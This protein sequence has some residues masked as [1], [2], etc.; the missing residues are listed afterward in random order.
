MTLSS[1]LSIGTLRTTLVVS[2]EQP[3]PDDLGN[4]IRS[5]LIAGLRERLARRLERSADSS[6]A[7]WVIRSIRADALVN[8]AW[9]ADEIAYTVATGLAHSLSKEMS[10]SGDGINS[11]RFESRAAQLAQYLIDRL[12]HT[13]NRWYHARFDGLRALPLSAALRTALTTDPA[14]G[15]SA[16][17]HLSALA[18][19]RAAEAMTTAD[20]RRVLHDF[21]L[22]DDRGGLCVAIEAVTIAWS[23]EHRPDRE[24]AAALWLFASVSGNRVGGATLERAIHLFVE[25]IAGRRRS[26]RRQQSRGAFNTET[27]LVRKATVGATDAIRSWSSAGGV[28][29]LL[30]DVDVEQLHQLSWRLTDDEA[31]SERCLALLTLGVAL[32]GTWSPALGTDSV[33]LDLFRI[34]VSID[35]SHIW[36]TATA[37]EQAGIRDAAEATLTRFARR[38]PGFSSSTPAFLRSNALSVTASIECEPERIVVRLS[39]PP[40][41]VLLAMTGVTRRRYEIDWLSELP[42]DVFPE[43]PSS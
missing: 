29:L 34:P 23:D 19:R 13:A 41:Y 16:L 31:I 26:D 8:A 22:I 14:E 3:N 2:L 12:D 18:R 40:L 36:S 27:A 20:C 30:P 33:L 43:D 35:L 10:G 24:D 42:F 21:G 7:V 28:F 1:R 32:N 25:T 38:L 39:R 17:Q 6:N 11:I 15:L 4:Q 5:A 37:A 9:G